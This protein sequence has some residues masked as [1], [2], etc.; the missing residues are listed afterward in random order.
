MMVVESEPSLH[1]VWQYIHISG[2]WQEDVARRESMFGRDRDRYT[3]LCSLTRLRLD[4]HVASMPG[5]DSLD[6]REAQSVT[7]I[8]RRIPPAVEP[9]KEVRQIFWRD[10]YPGIADR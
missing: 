6:N 3:Y 10:A 8:F 2:I 7:G 9:F 1:I 5:N 4:R